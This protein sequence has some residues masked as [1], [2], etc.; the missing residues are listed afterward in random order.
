MQSRIL[1]HNGQ[2]IVVTSPMHSSRS[3]E[4][5]EAPFYKVVILS[6]ALLLRLSSLAKRFSAESKDLHLFFQRARIPHRP[7]HPE[8]SPGSENPRIAQREP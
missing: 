2:M 5:R 1:G 4:S 7:A 3:V 6:E 8:I